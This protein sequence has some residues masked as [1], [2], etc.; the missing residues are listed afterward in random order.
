MLYKQTKD[1]LKTLNDDELSK[2]LYEVVGFENTGFLIKLKRHINAKSDKELGKGESV[3][4]GM[5]LPEK[6]RCSVNTLQFVIEGID[7]DISPIG[8]IRFHD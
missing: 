4:N 2:R 5:P 1:E 7:F 3:K 6:I 8:E